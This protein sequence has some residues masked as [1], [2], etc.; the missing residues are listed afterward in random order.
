MLSTPG[1]PSAFQ[2]SAAVRAAA[3]PAPAQHGTRSAGGH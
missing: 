3:A 1:G 2:V